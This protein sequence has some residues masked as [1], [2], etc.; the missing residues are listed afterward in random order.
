MSKIEQLRLNGQLPSPKGVALAIMELCRREDASIEAVTRVVQTDPALAARLLRLAN[1]AALRAARPVAAVPDAVMRLGM[2]AVRQVAMGFSMVDQ[3]RHGQC[4][5]FDYDRFWS[6]SLLMAVAMQAL[7]ARSRAGS[8]EEMFTCGLM[9]RIG[10]LALA[11]VYPA[12][13]AE[14]LRQSPSE[15]DLAALERQHL[16]ADHHEFTAAILED[17]GVPHALI[18]PVIHHEA[19]DAS[20]FTEGSRPHRLAHLFHHGKRIAD[21]GLAPESERSGL[22]SELMLLGG[23]LGLDANEQGSLIDG[24]VAE[25]RQWSELLKVPAGALPSF[26]AM[27]AAP[28]PKNAELQALHPSMRVLLVED[29][30]ASRMLMEKLLSDIV[31]PNVHSATNGSEALAL[32]LEI[33]PQI[34]VTDWLMPVMDGVEFCKALRATDW[35]Q[36]MYVIMLTG[37]DNED[38]VTRAFEAGVDDY[39]TKPLKVRSLRA[40]MRAALHYVQLL[41]A[42]ESDRAKLK[43]F[44]AELAISNRKLEHYA[45]TD[46]LT[47]L[48]NRR[49]GM[50][51]L[52]QAWSGAGRSGHG[53]AVM[54][55]DIDR[56]KGI[57][58]THG[59]AVGDKVLTRVGKLIRASARREDHVSRIG[60]EE[61]LVICHNADLRSTVHAAER[62]RQKVRSEVIEA[63]GVR[64]QASISIGV[65]SKE[66][67]M[68]NA[69]ALMAAADRAL[70]AAKQNGRDRTCLNAGG[71]LMLNRP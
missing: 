52:G 37:V 8:P 33:M 54:M 2:A 26:A 11:T 48:P 61:F 60:G 22:I 39:V 29:E 1:A 16:R 12:E 36:S 59:H 32:A 43:Q 6:H 51:V 71:K 49:A 62:L 66:D 9:A 38:E 5:G 56:F 30:P 58:D 42:W 44:T 41:D 46:L 14:L 65:A 13:Y 21:M 20:G 28:A 55:I 53:L 18:E 24:I 57:N 70:Y 35:G 25:W 64:L 27:A 34:V 68:A 45:M 17:C 23:K 67:G 69:D 19:P 3:H 40:R 47:G 4:E 50:D 63:D 10:C 7:A 15:R 31:G